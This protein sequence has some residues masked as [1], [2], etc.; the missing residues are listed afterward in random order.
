MSKATIVCGWLFPF[1]LV[2][3]ATG[4]HNDSMGE[5]SDAP[6]SSGK[7]DAAAQGF[8]DAPRPPQDAFVQLDAQVSQTPDAGG[9]GLFCTT[10]SQCTNAGECCL[11][12]GGPTGFC[13]P[14]TIILGVCTPFN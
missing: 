12:L 14:G 11:T 1:A 6:T 5:P 9:G 10:N 13:A 2:G 7:H 4:G 8:L 3:C